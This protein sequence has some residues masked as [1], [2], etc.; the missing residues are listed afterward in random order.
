MT[1]EKHKRKAKV[2][3]DTNVFISA[4]LFGGIPEEVIELV[5]DGGIILLTSNAILFESAR[6]LQEKFKF[7]REVIFDLVSEIKRIAQMVEPKIKLN[8]IKFDPSDNPVLECAV[9]AKADYI[10]TGDKKHL[11]SLKKY[12]HI[13]IRLASEFMREI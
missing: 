2:V 4:L 6:V 8:V 3:L 9:E 13:I 12:N 11:R 7:P 1:L 10:V 5:R